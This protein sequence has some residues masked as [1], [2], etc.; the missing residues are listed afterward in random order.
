MTRHVILMSAVLTATPGLA[1]AGP[2]RQLYN[3][4]RQ[5]E[6]GNSA[7]AANAV[8]DGGRS[9]GPYQIQ[10][11]YWRDSGVPGKYSDVRGTAYAEKVMLAYWQRYCPTALA[12]G[13]SQTLARVH[14]GGPSGARKGSTLKYWRKVSVAMSD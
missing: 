6:T 5:V 14:N 9:L 4:I 11:K 2:S 1:L 7:D 8:G 12:R 10:W 13:D 3:A